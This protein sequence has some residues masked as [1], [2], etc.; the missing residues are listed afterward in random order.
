MTNMSRAHVFTFKCP[1]PHSSSDF[2]AICD[3]PVFCESLVQSEGIENHSIV[4][5]S[6]ETVHLE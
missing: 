2:S 6:N 4:E 3:V 5:G 1:V